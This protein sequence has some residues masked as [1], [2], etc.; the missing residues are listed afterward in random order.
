MPMNFATAAP[1]SAGLKQPLVYCAHDP[2]PHPG[3]YARTLQR[4]TQSALITRARRVV[5]LS[6]YAAAR[7]HVHRVPARKVVT[8]PL[9]SVFAP[10]PHA[11]RA[12][13]GPLRLA[14][15]GR[16]IGYKGVDILADALPSWA[17]RDDWRLT[18]AG[19]DRRSPTK[20]PRASIFHRSSA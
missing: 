2:E 8:A 11:A 20:P 5:A 7:L 15:V 4:V 9:Q 3:D 18:V 6:D 13:A 10:A 12:E 1:L 17:G 19:W 14:F 16:M